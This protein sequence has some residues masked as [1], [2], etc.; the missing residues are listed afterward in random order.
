MRQLKLILATLILT[1]PSFAFADFIDFE[2]LA[3]A[4]AVTDQFAGVEFSSNSGFE[5][6]I[7]AQSGIGFGDNFICTRPTEGAINC[8]Q[9]T[10]LTFS[11]LVNGLTFWQVGDNSSGTVALVDVFVSGV[12]AAT[13]DILGFSDF[14]TPNLVD[15]SAFSDVSSIRIYDVTDPGGLGWDNFEFFAEGSVSVPEPGTLGLLGLG[16]LGLAA[17]RRRKV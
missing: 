14:N 13:V 10:I 4:E 15:L 3:N 5:N 6:S 9:E 1:V 16:L 2:G 7:T 12:F 11:S 17:R 8:T